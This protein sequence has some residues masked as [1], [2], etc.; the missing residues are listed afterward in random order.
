MAQSPYL[1][2]SLQIVKELSWNGTSFLSGDI[3][4]NTSVHW[5]P[6]DRTDIN[7]STIGTK[8]ASATSIHEICDEH[9][10][11]SRLPLGFWDLIDDKLILSDQEMR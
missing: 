5:F 10:D 7:A 11:I 8:N 6:L 3:F 4:N 1:M 2:K 9:V